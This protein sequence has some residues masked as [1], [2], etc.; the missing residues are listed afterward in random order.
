MPQ[1][2]RKASH[3]SDASVPL[4]LVQRSPFGGPPPPDAGVRQANPM[5]PNSPFPHHEAST[6]GSTS[7][8][9]ESFA[10]SSSVNRGSSPGRV[11][12]SDQKS[13][14]LGSSPGPGISPHHESSPNSTPPASDS[15]SIIDFATPSTADNPIGHR[16]SSSP[17]SRPA[18]DSTSASI[19]SSAGH[20]RLTEKPYELKCTM[21]HCQ[22]N[23][24]CNR[25]GLVACNAW[26][27]ID[28]ALIDRDTMTW[29]CGRYGKCSC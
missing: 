1:P 27:P 8:N 14:P 21:E 11:S 5:S 20:S 15:E 7:A 22:A 2:K 6:H 25:R 28:S 26:K 24:W 13:S 4:A 9:R 29:M 3:S 23:C 16:W 18:T 10:G 17:D 19:H 12:P